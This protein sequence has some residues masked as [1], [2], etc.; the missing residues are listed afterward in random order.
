MIKKKIKMI[1]KNLKIIS[2]KKVILLTIAVSTISIYAYNKYK[3]NMCKNIL[4][5]TFTNS[6]KWI[7]LKL[8][9]VKNISSDSRIFSFYLPSENHISNYHVSSFFFTK[10]IAQNGEEIIKYY[11]PISDPNKK[12]TIDFLIK[13]YEKGKMTPHIFGLKKDDILHFRGPIT[14]WNLKQNEFKEVFLIAGGTGIT[15]IYQLI[16]K[17]VTDPSE[18]TKV[19]LIFSNK[20]ENDI[21]LKNELDSLMEKNKERFKVTYFL[22]KESKTS[23]GNTGYIN[24]D[25]LKKVLPLPSSDMKIFVCGPPSM[26]KAISGEKKSPSEQGT[27]GGILGS[28][29]YTNDQVFKF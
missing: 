9:E 3:M 23:L 14:K 8:K 12:G 20:T 2:N 5:E 15:P 28:L 7:G 6:E 19:Y 1:F 18:K 21:L 25:F 24:K 13:K 26:V 29:G 27:V 22:S 4:I 10:F 11:T 17:I 16:K